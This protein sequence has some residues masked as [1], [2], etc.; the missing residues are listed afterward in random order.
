MTI[1]TTAGLALAT[2]SMTRDSS[3]IESVFT[4]SIWGVSAPF[5]EIAPADII[6]A[7]IA[8]ATKTVKMLEAELINIVVLLFLM[9]DLIRL[10]ITTIFYKKVGF[11]VNT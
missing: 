8:A 6:A 7:N 3:A 10:I 4:V 1:E 2:T 11:T 9:K 5:N